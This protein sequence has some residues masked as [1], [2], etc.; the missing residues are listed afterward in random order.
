[1]VEVGSCQNNPGLPHASRFF[2]VGPMGRT[3]AMIAPG[4]TG[5][6]V[7]PSVRQNANDFAMRAPAAL[8]DAAGALEPHMPAELRPEDWINPAYFGFNRHSSPRAL[9]AVSPSPVS[10]PADK[11]HPL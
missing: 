8:T 11:L 4:L 2:D 3:A 6:V 1:M 9:V 10:L 7:P 5:L